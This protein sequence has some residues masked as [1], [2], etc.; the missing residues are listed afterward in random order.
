MINFDFGALCAIG[1]FISRTYIHTHI[2][3]VFTCL[4]APTRVP[5]RQ[6]T[7]E[8]KWSLIASLKMLFVSFLRSNIFP[9]R[10][11]YRLVD[12]QYQES[13][14]MMSR[15]KCFTAWQYIQFRPCFANIQYIHAYRLQ[16]TDRKLI[17]ISFFSRQIYSTGW[18]MDFFPY[19]TQI[20]LLKGDLK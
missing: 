11:I 2:H 19:F 5:F 9:H 15:L 16:Y 13:E 20:S 12:E 3:Q 18:M 10:S 8:V 7:L 6:D 4:H 17:F 14:M 1:R